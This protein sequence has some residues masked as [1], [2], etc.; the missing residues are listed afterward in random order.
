VT[1]LLGVW[2]GGTLLMWVVATA[3]F[4]TVDRV[5][6]R[7]T[8]QAAPALES[9]PEAARRPLLRHLASEINRLLFR[10][11]GA[12]QLVLGAAVLAL[13]LWQAP[14]NTTNVSLAGAL[15]LLIAVMVVGITPAITNLGRTLDFVPRN[16]PPPEMASFG[17]L[18]A[19][20]SALDLVKLVLAAVLAWRAGR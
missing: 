16:P 20:Y 7:P 18:H 11:W 10:L 6:S 13:L 14:R 2:I 9:A 8:A 19:A 17:K 4:R 15:L 5:L 12:A 3:N 1:F